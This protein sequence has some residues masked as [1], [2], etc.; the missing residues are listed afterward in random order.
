MMSTASTV[1]EFWM[2]DTVRLAQW[3]VITTVLETPM[4]RTMLA[5]QVIIRF[6][7][8]PE[9]LSLPPGGGVGDVDG[10][11]VWVPLVD[12]AGLVGVT[13]GEVNG[14]EMVGGD[15]MIDR[16]PESWCATKAAMPPARAT[17]PMAMT[18]PRIHHMRLPEGGFG[19][20]PGNGPP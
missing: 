8:I 20:G 3:P 13:D 10:L 11:D 16:T 1:I 15:V 7:L 14:R 17:T 4:T 6:S 2:P 5:L 9:I 12:G 18:V 19:G